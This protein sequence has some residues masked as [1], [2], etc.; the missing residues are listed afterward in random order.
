MATHPVVRFEFGFSNSALRLP[1]A[2]A[3]LACGH[4]QRVEVKPTV[5]ACAACSRE[6]TSCQHASCP[7]GSTA[8][9]RII[10]ITNPHLENDRITQI[11]DEIECE[12]CERESE[13][14]AWL[15]ALPAG[16]VHHARFDP[17][18]SPGSYH[19]YRNDPTSPS[20]FMLLGS[21]PATRVFDAA[22]REAK[23]SPLS[24][25]ECA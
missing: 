16:A 5:Y 21:V 15:R 22:L 19:L 12:Q 9:F 18:F 7:C 23:I 24:P 3:I 11:G 20:G 4:A 17:R 8:G 25:T 1:Y 14:M 6:T 13:Q 10:H 2:L